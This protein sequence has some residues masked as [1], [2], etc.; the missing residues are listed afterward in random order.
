MFGGETYLAPSLAA[1]SIS[2]V[3]AQTIP[4]KL[5]VQLA[6]LSSQQRKTLFLVGMG[7][8]NREIAER[9]GVAVKTVKFHV[10]NLLAKLGLKNRVEAARIVQ[11]LIRIRRR[12]FLIKL[13]ARKMN[14]VQDERTRIRGRD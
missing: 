10:T 1:R 2:A 4:R 6:S 7:L 3:K 5:A 14:R 11:I 9:M 12:A 13:A 8:S